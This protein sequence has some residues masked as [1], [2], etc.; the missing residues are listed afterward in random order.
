MKNSIYFLEKAKDF[1]LAQK[2]YDLVCEELSVNCSVAVL[3][4]DIKTVNGYDKVVC[5]FDTNISL[6]ENSFTY[7]VGQ[8][9]ADI[10]GFNF[11]KREM[12]K[13]IDLFSQ[14]FMG[15]VNIPLESE[16]TEVSVL[17]CAAGFVGAGISLSQVLKA[18]NAKLS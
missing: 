3:Q 2:L 1:E 16:F 14:S 17:L 13:S 7:S 5:E 4:K 10:C 11:Q 9:D 8:S 6:P 15:R 18:I 12:S